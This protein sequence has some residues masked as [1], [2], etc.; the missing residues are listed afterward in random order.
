MSTYERQKDN[1]DRMVKNKKTYHK[2]NMW[3]ICC[4]IYCPLPDRH[5]WHQR[6]GRHSSN[7]ALQHQTKN[8]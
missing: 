2:S 1:G 6:L 5:W 3:S 4:G 8:I 7:T